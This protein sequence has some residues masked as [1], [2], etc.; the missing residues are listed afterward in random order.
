MIN[1]S[2]S[3]V[4][5]Q[6]QEGSPGE[7]RLAFDTGLVSPDDFPESADRSCIKA[8]SYLVRSR[9]VAGMTRGGE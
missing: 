7:W 2:E 9:S 3:D 5:F 6:I 1:S 8:S 4:I